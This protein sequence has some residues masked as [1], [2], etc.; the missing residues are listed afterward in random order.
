MFSG[1]PCVRPCVRP[2]IRAC[3]HVCVPVCVRA[4]VHFSLARLLENGLTD[5]RPIFTSE[6]SRVKD[7]LIRFWPYMVNFH[8]NGGTK[9]GK[10]CLFS[11][12]EGERIDGFAP[13]FYQ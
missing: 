10:I 2:S 4:S 13:K 7:E 9:H 6:P 3:I 8:G 11:M 1:C 5:L 12:I